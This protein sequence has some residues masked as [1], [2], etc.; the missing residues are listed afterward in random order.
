M[1]ELMIH[2]EKVY[3]ATLWKCPKKKKMLEFELGFLLFYYNVYYIY[4]MAIVVEA[5]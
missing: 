5:I 1:I 3:E 4:I 2:A